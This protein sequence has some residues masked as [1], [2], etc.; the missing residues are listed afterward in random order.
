ML[1][2]GFGA[3]LSELRLRRGVRVQSKALDRI[4]HMYGAHSE[5]AICAALT[6]F[7]FPVHI[8]AY[9]GIESSQLLPLNGHQFIEAIAASLALDGSEIDLLTQQ[10]AYEYEMVYNQISN[11][12]SH[13]ILPDIITLDQPKAQEHLTTSQ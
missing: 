9:C 1:V 5:R 3:S 7:G 11:E 8:D 13:T 2:L 10:L 6:S 12:L 4:I